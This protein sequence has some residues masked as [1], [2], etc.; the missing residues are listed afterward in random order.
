MEFFER[1]SG[2][3]MHANLY[4]PGLDRR[5]LNEH[6]CLDIADFCSN[7]VSTVNEMHT[8]LSSNKI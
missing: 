1:V 8:T 5:I 3:R 2:A 7:S 4:R 6:I